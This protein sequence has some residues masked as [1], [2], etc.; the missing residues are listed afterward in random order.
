MCVRCSTG[1]STIIPVG[2][3]LLLLFSFSLSLYLCLFSFF[4]SLLCICLISVAVCAC[5]LQ[6]C[7][8]IITIP[9]LTSMWWMIRGHNASCVSFFLF[10]FL[11]I[12]VCARA[13]V[14]LRMLCTVCLLSVCLYLSFL[15]VCVCRVHDQSSKLI[16]TTKTEFLRREN[17]QLTHTLPLHHSRLFVTY[18]RIRTD[19]RHFAGCLASRGRCAFVVPSSVAFTK[20]SWKE[21]KGELILGWSYW[22]IGNFVEPWRIISLWEIA[23]DSLLR[24]REFFR[25]VLWLSGPV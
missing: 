5:V 17:W 6:S 9:T 23:L 4:F 16:L 12:N 10:L 15:F 3:Y 7:C 19:I 21:K 1:P 2:W 11:S 8:N 22:I 18:T 24:W 13:R 14:L 20:E 25:S